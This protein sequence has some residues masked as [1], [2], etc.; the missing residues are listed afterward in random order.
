MN[1]YVMGSTAE[2][3]NRFKV[4]LMMQEEQVKVQREMR[5]ELREIKILLKEFLLKAKAIAV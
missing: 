4:L 1:R 2:H 5:D 3:P